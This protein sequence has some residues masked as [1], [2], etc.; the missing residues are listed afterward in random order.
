MEEQRKVH[1]DGRQMRVVAHP[2][3]ARLLGLLRVEGPATA[4]GLAGQLGTNSGAT[5]YHLRQLAEVGL[6]EEDAS[7][8]QGRE[9]WWRAAH[10]VSSW[11]ADDYKDDPDAA[12]A[13]A[14][15]ESYW[16]RRF[17]D[18]AETWQRER[19]DYSSEWRDAATFSDYWLELSAEQ[20]RAMSEEIDGVIERYRTAAP[21][22]DKRNVLFYV[23]GFPMSD[24]S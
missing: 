8:G 17:V 4:T 11:R 24:K 5:S 20:L 18:N 9:R 14:W 2:L 22:P 15:M 10:D 1:L 19:D 3:R 13:A 6:V 23:Y 21:S 7:R 16:L 12:A